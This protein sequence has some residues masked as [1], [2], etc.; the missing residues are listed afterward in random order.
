MESSE[1]MLLVQLMDSIENG[2]KKLKFSYKSKDKQEFEKSKKI[3][4]DF[5]NKLGFLLKKK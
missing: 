5:Q 1:I 2:F 4:L 3:L